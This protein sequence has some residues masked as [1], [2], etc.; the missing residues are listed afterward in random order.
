VGSHRRPEIVIVP[1]DRYVDAG[2]APH[3][4]TLAA[5]R[6][7]RELV[8]RIAQLNRID[9]VAVFGSVARGDETAESD[10]DL[11]VTPASDAT[12]F[13]LAQFELDMQQL[14]GRSVDAVSRRALD[15]ERDANILADAVAL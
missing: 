1:F 13:D 8:R 7:Q 9:D 2:S 3:E 5:L 15:D 11:L 6:R 14:T 12:L 10:L 4:T